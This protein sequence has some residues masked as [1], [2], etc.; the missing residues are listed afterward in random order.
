M[1]VCVNWT[2]ITFRIQHVITA[3]LMIS[4]CGSIINVQKVVDLLQMECDP[5]M[6]RTERTSVIEAMVSKMME[7][8]C[9]QSHV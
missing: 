9:S 4:F 5:M 7:E 8:L 1:C 2:L 3:M 6:K